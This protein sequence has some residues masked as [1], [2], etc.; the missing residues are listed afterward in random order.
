MDQDICQ[1]QYISVL[2]ILRW[3]SINVVHFVHLDVPHTQFCSRFETVFALLLGGVEA[4][5]LA[6]PESLNG[7]LVV[8]AVTDEV[9]SEEVRPVTKLNA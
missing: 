3:K 9:L 1:S 7:S 5:R 2:L 6:A 8:L 4:V